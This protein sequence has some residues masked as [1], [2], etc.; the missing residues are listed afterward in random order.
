VLPGDTD[1]F[2]AC[3]KM[4]PLCVDVKLLPEWMAVRTPRPSSEVAVAIP[5][6]IFVFC[7][8]VREAAKGTGV[9]EP[10]MLSVTLAHELGHELLGD[11]SH[12][13]CGIM[14]PPAR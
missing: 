7:Q 4:S 2:A 14:K 13:P 10:L 11:S 9:G 6:T 5:S 8:R 1:K 3:D 12:S